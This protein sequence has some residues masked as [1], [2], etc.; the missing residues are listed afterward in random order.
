MKVI[1]LKLSPAQKTK[2]RKGLR[3]R[4]NKKNKPVI[5]G[6]GVYM[7]V[8]PENFNALT[9]TFEST[10]GKEFN[11]DAQEIEANQNPDA[12]QDPEVKQAIEGS[13]LF[14]RIRR[15][16]KK[17]KKFYSTK[18]GSAIRNAVKIGSKVAI[19]SA[20]NSLAGT[21]LAPLMPALKLANMKYGEKGIDMAIKKIGL[22]MHQM[23][24]QGLRLGGEMQSMEE[25]EAHENVE[26]LLKQAPDMEEGKGMHGKGMHGDGLRLRGDGMHGDGLT[27]NRGSPINATA[28]KMS[29]VQTQKQ[30]IFPNFLLDKQNMLPVAGQ[31][32][33]AGRGMHGDGLRAGGKMHKMNGGSGGGEIIGMDAPPQTHALAKP[34]RLVKTSMISGRSR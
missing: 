16:F 13:G 32:L 25:K 15:G 33:R 14:S 34:Q 7:L 4:I 1:E 10:R 6:E 24:G 19:K 27:V 3:I 22:G 9:K 29:G 28:V 21:P 20:I 26:N 31:G 11:L 23:V 30:K 12:I 5:E 8:K 2:L 17:L 18:V